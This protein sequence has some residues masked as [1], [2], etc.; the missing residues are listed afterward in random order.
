MATYGTYSVGADDLD[1]ISRSA[2]D[3]GLFH[4]GTNGQVTTNAGLQINVGAIPAGAAI[5]NGTRLAAVSAATPTATAQ[6]ATLDR[7]DWVYVD[8][9]GTVGIAAGTAATV[10]T[11]PVLATTR[12]ALGE[13][14]ILSTSNG[15]GA[16]A[17]GNILD[18]RQV[19]YNQPRRIIKAGTE[20]VSNST[21]FQNDDDFF[22]SVAANDYWLVKQDL[23]INTASAAGFKFDWSL[24]AGATYE[25]YAVANAVPTGN[26][27]QYTANGS[28]TVTL[29]TGTAYVLGTLQI[30]TVIT[31]GATAGTA[32]FRWAQSTADVSNTQVTS[33]APAR[34]FAWR[35]L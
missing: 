6:H 21:A 16:I 30:R 10:P 4:L 19:L 23:I 26:T 33:V 24:P 17:S 11:L 5:V 20:T 2:N 7:R 15:G 8:T 25:A 1:F 29:P 9:A 13:L 31:I 35:M 18:R 14:Q 28:G 27:T 32:Q 12:L 22:F 34:L 3:H